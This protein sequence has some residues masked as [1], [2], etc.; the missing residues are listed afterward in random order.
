M[1][2]IFTNS[3]IYRE[4]LKISQEW[5]RLAQEGFHTILTVYL[6][7]IL[8]NKLSPLLYICFSYGGV[9]VTG[10]RSLYQCHATYTVRYMHRYDALFKKIFQETRRIQLADRIVLIIDECL[11]SWHSTSTITAHIFLLAIVRNLKTRVCN[12]SAVIFKTIF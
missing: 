1:Q 2:T 4:Y 5:V 7:P 10:S 3:H 8:I 6:L 11:S 9:L 12:L